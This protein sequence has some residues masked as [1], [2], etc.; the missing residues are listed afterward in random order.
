MKRWRNLDFEAV[1][2]ANRKQAL[3]PEGATVIEPAGTA[4]GHG[5]AAGRRAAVPRWWSCPGRRASCTPC[6]SEA[7][8]TEPFRAAVGVAERATSS[9]CCGCSGSPSRRSPRRCAWP[10]REIDGFDDLEIT[11]CLRRGEVEVVVRHEPAAEAAWTAL[12]GADRRPARDTLFSTDGS[13][14]DEQVAGLLDGRTVATAE[15]CTGGLMAARL[16][17][18]PGASAYVAGGTVTYANEAK[19]G[20]A[21]RG[22]GADRAP[23]GGLARGGRRD[24]RRGAGAASARTWRSPSPASPA[25]AAAPRRSRSGT[26]CWCAKRADGATLARDVRMPG[27]RDEIRDRSTTV[28]MHLLRR[29]LRGEEL[30]ALSGARDRGPARCAVPGARAAGRT[31]HLA[32][33]ADELAARDGAARGR[34][35]VAAR[36]AG[37][38]RRDARRTESAPSGR[39]RA[40]RSPG[41]PLRSCRRARWWACRGGVRACC[42]LELEDAEA[43]A[44]RMRDGIA[45]ALAG[46]GLHEP[47]ERPFWP[48]VTLARARGGARLCRSRR[49]P[50]RSAALRRRGADALQQPHATPRA[51]VTRA[52]E[53]LPLGP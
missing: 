2:A 45:S 25:P 26:V 46:A 39:S 1:R 31:R 53:R 42:A 21:R 19:V 18:R 16:T 29:L 36:D 11:T 7:V 34:A 38:P 15:S 4:P 5:G 48:H 50:S 52:L 22:P 40:V 12:E 32:R 51:P 20:A 33:V 41:S 47:E 3:V 49:R 28:G 35:E 10:R 9:R 30:P 13:T 37:V 44:G 14:V 8:E 23:R 24:G 27:D 17:E 43:R 6:G